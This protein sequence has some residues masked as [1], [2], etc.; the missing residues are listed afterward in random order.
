MR[1]GHH[2]NRRPVRP[3][4][5]RG[6]RVEYTLP[7]DASSARWA[8]RLTTEFLL[9]ERSPAPAGH[10]EDEAELIVSEL[11]TNAV[12]HGRSRCR[13]RLTSRRRALTIEV[14]DDGPGHP[15]PR[16]AGAGQEGGRGLV[17]VRHLARRLRTTRHPHGGKTVRAV[18][19]L[20]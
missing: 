3:R 17:L 18:L 15:V 16:R 8:R 1:A 14:A 2:Q 10:R 19:A 11:V 6:A 13:L 7:A 4:L 9:S 12:R 20:A 5:A